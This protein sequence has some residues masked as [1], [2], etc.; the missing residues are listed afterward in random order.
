MCSASKEACAGGREAFS[1]VLTLQRAFNKMK[2]LDLI[3]SK[4]I[5]TLAFTIYAVNAIFDK[6]KVSFESIGAF[7]IVMIIIILYNLYYDARRN[8]K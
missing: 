5:I 8:L 2:K 1:E 7:F 4:L 6:E 3:I